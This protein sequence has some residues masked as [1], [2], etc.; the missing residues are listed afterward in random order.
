M[1]G[2]VSSFE[3]GNRFH[4][5]SGNK[6][7]TLAEDLSARLSHDCEK[8][9][10]APETVVVQSR[11]MERWLL[12]KL[13]ELRGISANINFPFPR[14]FVSDYVFKPLIGNRQEDSLSPDEYTWRIFSLLPEI[15]SDPALSELKNYLGNYPDELKTFQLSQKIAGLFEQYLIFRPD[16][17]RRWDNGENPFGNSRTGVWQ[18][19]LWQRTVRKGGRNFAGLYQDFMRCAWPNLYKD[20]PVHIPDFEE[21]KKLKRIFL[22]GF[23]SM[24]PA[25]LD[26]F[27]AVSRYV[28]V[29][30][31]YLNPCQDEWQYDLS[32][33][34]GLR[35]FLG[36]SRNLVEKA[37]CREF[38][39]QSGRMEDFESLYLGGGNP[40]L[41]SLGAQGR[42]FF[43]L[44]SE[45]DETPLPLFNEQP[46]ESTLLEKIQRDI[47]F[48]LPPA[49]DNLVESADHSI[50]IHSCH[51]QMREVEVLFEN[52]TAM[53]EK[54]PSL[55]PRDVLVLVPKID[56]Y[57]PYIEAV[58]K[59][60]EQDDPRWCFVTVADRSQYSSSLE[61]ET[62]LS[63][64]EL[65]RS[66]FK[67]AE[68]MSLLEISAVCQNFG[69]DENK[70]EIIRNWLVEA[71]VSWGIDGKFRKEVTGQEFE[72]QSWRNVIDRLLAGFALGSEQ[73]DSG[74]IYNSS[75]E[76]SIL[77][78]HCCEGGNAE[79]LGSLAEYLQRL[80][81]LREKL[82]AADNDDND[83]RFSLNW[84]DGLLNG[85][86]HDFFIESSE[87]ARSIS[88][89]RQAVAS[90]LENI[91]KSGFSEKISPEI[92]TYELR[93][94]FQFSTISGGF[95]RGGIT[96]CEARPM[97]SIPS[98]V[99]CLLG[100]DEKSFPRSQN[101]QTFDLMQ[102]RPRFGDRS[103]RN[104]DRFLFMESL[105][106][107]RDCFYLSYVGQGVKDNEPLPP[108]IVINELLD[109]LNEHYT[110]A[111]GKLSD[112]LCTLHPLQAFSWKYFVPQDKRREYEISPGIIS[113]S[114]E[115][116]RAAEQ[117]FEPPRSFEFVSGEL[118]DI[119]EDL[120]N[121]T[122]DDL[123]DFFANPARYFLTKRLQ[124]YPAV[125]DVPELSGREMFELNGL[126]RFK[127]AQSVLKDHLSNWRQLD[128]QALAEELRRRFHA[129]GMLPVGAWGDCIFEE[130]VR[131]FFPFAEHVA[132]ST[133]EH[134]SAFSSELEFD[135]KIRLRAYFDD[136]FQGEA[137]PRQ[138]LFR[139]SKLDKKI[140]YQLRGILYHLAAEASAPE[141]LDN[142]PVET[143][144]IGR[145]VTYSIAENGLDRAK[146]I[147]SGLTDIY[148]R[149]LKRPLA[150]F[151]ETSSTYIK[152]YLETGSM[153]AAMDKARST[154]QGG[155][156][157]GEGEDEYFRFCF[158]T[159]FKDW[160]GFRSLASE[161]SEIFTMDLNA[162]K[163][164]GNA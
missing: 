102:M 105:L 148:L 123:C 90:I 162:D 110:A 114:A 92:M 19:K 136:F 24:P 2:A 164:G 8:S 1:M 113:Y 72:D 37:D 13:A 80:F 71:N 145:D 88:I 78:L 3:K 91:E 16:V 135:G 100:M 64:L 70:L 57:A 144:M 12:L 94:Y 141:L 48:N 23:S 73:E 7:E 119:P 84:W 22:F 128:K 60:V 138:V 25:F 69:L 101:K 120:L 39:E 33:K 47:Q 107:A 129:A 9:V 34:A 38:Y 106:S 21:L 65:T 18:W 43:G 158:G 125:H 89:I 118:E 54:N 28:D 45:T 17:I 99:V 153:E 62:F 50:Q 82:Y 152:S 160:L 151:P 95:L 157:P 61:A 32:E 26:L 131:D 154:W 140:K 98:R 31:Y 44:L 36:E 130:L 29:Y 139:F 75:A 121:I 56:S 41:S 109:Y 68:V 124:I 85:I 108:S 4:L 51:S 97:R 132:K 116:A 79:M 59:S 52:L 46:P 86:I 134:I 30:F 126:D 115:N 155:F 96:F 87:F 63:I 55:L 104:D 74:K 35:L 146:N 161:M 156:H 159:Q 81:E 67:A 53:F 27:M 143:V 142:S 150:I 112:L 6:L 149:G 14:S 137:S 49:E 103:S 163:G 111:D 76:K 66:R 93:R 11:G 58:F 40:F 127:L 42:E 10:L 133:G 117:A 77:P 83:E 15:I 122:L 147:L 20:T 5:I